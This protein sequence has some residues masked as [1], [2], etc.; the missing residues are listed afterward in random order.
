METPLI[1]GLLLVLVLI[2]SANGSTVVHDPDV[3]DSIQDSIDTA[4]WMGTVLIPSGTY[5]DRFTIPSG[6]SVIGQGEVVVDGGGQGTV[7]AVEGDGIF[8][9]NLTARNG[10]MTGDV[11]MGEACITI[12]GL[13][14]RIA[15]VTVTGCDIGLT[16]AESFDLEA[17]GIRSSHTLRAIHIDSSTDVSI[18]DINIRDNNGTAIFIESDVHQVNI[19]GGHIVNVTS[20][21]EV[22]GSPA[23]DSA[24]LELTLRD[25]VLD[26]IWERGIHIEA[27]L[28]STFRDITLDNISVS[29]LSTQSTALGA[30]AFRFKRTREL[31]ITNVSAYNIQSHGQTTVFDGNGWSGTQDVG[32]GINMYQ[33]NYTM[34][35]GASFLHI[36]NEAISL[37]ESSNV[38]IDEV[39][40]RD[41]GYNGITVV[42]SYG[43]KFRN[44]SIRE[45]GWRGDTSGTGMQVAV[46]SSMRWEN[47]TIADNYQVGTYFS[48]SDTIELVDVS[49]LRNRGGGITMAGIDL[50]TATRLTLKDNPLGGIMT[51]YNT[52]NI[53][54]ID[55]HID[56]PGTIGLGIGGSG[57]HSYITVLNTTFTGGGTGTGINRKGVGFMD[58]IEN[59]TFVDLYTGLHLR[60]GEYLWIM[61]N[62]FR[63]NTRAISLLEQVDRVTIGDNLFV[64]NYAAIT[65]FFRPKGVT[66]R[67][68]EFLDNTISVLQNPPWNGTFYLGNIWSDYAGYDDGSGGRPRGDGI[69]DT[70]L[71]HLGL[72]NGPMFKDMDGDGI[73][74]LVDRFPM[75]R[76]E[77]NDTDRDGTGDNED[78]FPLNAKWVLDSDGDGVADGIDEAP[79]DPDIQFDSDGDGVDDAS[80]AFPFD[81]EQIS[82]RDHDGFGDSTRGSIHDAFPDDPAEWKDSDGDGLGDNTDYLPRFH[83]GSIRAVSFAGCGCLLLFRYSL[84]RKDAAGSE[85]EVR[86]PGEVKS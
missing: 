27:R 20:G 34:I 61:N 35:S 6:T 72:D 83:N 32:V 54:I 21:L 69:G 10:T 41:M 76:D 9:E 53:S 58:I 60:Q 30:A 25:M 40:I 42:G 17:G 11:L 45:N 46:V 63:N 1:V 74:D 36:D 75:D 49:Y 81:S 85:D 24:D 4:G 79:L 59:C 66:V 44:M 70:G 64:D 33:A 51:T 56:S 31:T 80:D 43:I 26:T 38:V 18:R 73:P 14:N 19:N 48:F 5:D 39:D 50:F 37:L 78:D 84:F 15:N 23:P 71:P 86:P 29:N 57:N 82:D 2:T 77:W 65:E 62:T 22:I 3:H 7:V 55:S 28:H 47:I 12:K 67:G 68:N 52:F 8:L 13:G 16:I